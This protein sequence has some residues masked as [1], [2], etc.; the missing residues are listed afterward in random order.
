[1]NSTLSN[2]NWYYCTDN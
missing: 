1:M 2:K